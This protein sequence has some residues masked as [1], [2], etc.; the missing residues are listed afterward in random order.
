ML[1]TGGRLPSAFASHPNPLPFLSVHPVAARETARTRPTASMNSRRDSPEGRAHSR[2]TWQRTPAAAMALAAPNCHRA[3]AKDSAS[4]S[5]GRQLTARPSDTAFST[6]RTDS[7]GYVP[8]SASNR[9]IAYWDSASPTATCARAPRPLLKR[10]CWLPA[11]RGTSAN[12]GP[13]SSVDAQRIACYRKATPPVPRMEYVSPRRD[14][15]TWAS[16]T[17]V[18]CPAIS[19]PTVDFAAFP[20][21][22]LPTGTAASSRFPRA[23]PVQIRVRCQPPTD[24]RASVS[25]NACRGLAATQKATPAPLT[26]CASAPVTRTCKI[27]RRDQPVSRGGPA[28]RTVS[29]G[30]LAASMPT[31]RLA[32]SVLLQVVCAS[33]SVRAMTSVW[34]ATAIC[35]PGLARQR[36][37]RERAWENAARAMPTASPRS[38]FW[39]RR[40]RPA[41]VA[42][43]ATAGSSSAP[44]GLPACQ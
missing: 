29:A 5:A 33:I 38:A 9:P 8:G 15:L 31:A 39:L 20:A 37:W 41:S 16:A 35:T 6:H 25:C 23:A 3:L 10:G 12:P 22:T 44:T 13:A 34:G 28:P 40:R 19:A 21:P 26:A 43:P 17:H 2:A 27:V 14:S 7:K 42:G 18:A 24:C 11:S 32:A 1:G 4:R 30:P 36:R